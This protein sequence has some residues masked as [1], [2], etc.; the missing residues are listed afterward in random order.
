MFSSNGLGSGIWAIEL[1]CF[2]IFFK[3]C[4]SSPLIRD[5]DVKIDCP[6]FYTLSGYLAIE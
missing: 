5:T 1:A 3:V 4:L 6:L 2:W